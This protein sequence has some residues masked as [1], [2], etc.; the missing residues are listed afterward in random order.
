MRI[1]FGYDSHRLVS[2]RRLVLGGVELSRTKGLLGHSDADALV[3]AVCDAVIGAV[4]AGD[5]GRLFPDTDP[6]YRDIS[7]LR[8]LEKV[9]V[10]AEDRGFRVHNVDSTIVLEK[11]KLR[12]HIGGMASNIAGALGIAAESVS[13]KAKTNEGMGFVGREDGVAAYAVVLLEER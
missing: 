4:A 9:R 5:I 1:G 10:L 12:G 2:G 3:H 8:L 11:P 6:A 7:S 13:I